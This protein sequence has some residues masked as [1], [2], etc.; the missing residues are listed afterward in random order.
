MTTFYH[1]NEKMYK[2]GHISVNYFKLK[3]QMLRKN[4]I[5]TANTSSSPKQE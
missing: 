2:Y 4:V 3:K 5:L 1:I